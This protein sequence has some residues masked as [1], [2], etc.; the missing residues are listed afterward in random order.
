VDAPRI[1]EIARN[2]AFGAVEAS[3]GNGTPAPSAP[4]GNV[5]LSRWTATSRA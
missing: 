2:L 1:E 3:G 4:A 5:D